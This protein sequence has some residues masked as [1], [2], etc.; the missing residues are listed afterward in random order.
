MFST[1]KILLLLHYPLRVLHNL[2][3]ALALI[4]LSEQ[5][6]VTNVTSWALKYEEEQMRV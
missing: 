6:I 3:N 5:S 4:D 2:C 1:L